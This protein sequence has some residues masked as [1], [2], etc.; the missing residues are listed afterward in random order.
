MPIFLKHQK[1]FKNLKTPSANVRKFYIFK[2]SYA[3][4]P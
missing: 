1:Y 2:I 3:D 4:R